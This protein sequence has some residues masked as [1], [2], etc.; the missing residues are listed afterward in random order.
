MVGIGGVNGWIDWQ[1]IMRSAKKGNS[2]NYKDDM[3]KPLSLSS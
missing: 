3:G 2:M 1:V